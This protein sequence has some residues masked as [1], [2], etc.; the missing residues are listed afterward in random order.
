[1]ETLVELD[2]EYAELAQGLGVAPYLRAPALGADPDFMAGLAGSTLEALAR[3]DGARPSGPWRCP[4][5]FPA[6]ACREA[7]VLESERR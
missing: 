5:N 4:P 6:C 2:H 3:E 1:V 7:A